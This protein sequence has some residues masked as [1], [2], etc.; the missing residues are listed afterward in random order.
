MPIGTVKTTMHKAFKQL[1]AILG[2]EGWE[3]IDE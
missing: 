2:G 3:P 1:Q